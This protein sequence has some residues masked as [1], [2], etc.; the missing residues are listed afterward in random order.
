MKFFLVLGK[1]KELSLAEA[2]VL[3]QKRLNTTSFVLCGEVL[4]FEAEKPIDFWKELG[5]SI[6]FGE[7]VEDI[8]DTKAIRTDNFFPFLDKEK[9]NFFGVSFYGEKNL[10]ALRFKIGMELKRELENSGYKIRLV[11]SKEETLSS[12]VVKTNKLLTRGMEAVIINCRDAKF[13]VSTDKQGITYNPILIGR[14]LAVQEFGDYEF[15]DYGRPKRDTLSGM[16]PPKLA[17]MMINLSGVEK[18]SI[19]LDPFCGSGTILT[20]AATMGY[21]N[22][23]GAD[24]SERAVEDSKKNFEWTS[25]SYKLSAISYNFFQSDVRGLSKKIGE[26]KVNAIITEPYLGPPLKGNESEE[27][28][29]KILSELSSLYKDTFESLY[30]ITKAGAMM[31]IVVPI[32]RINN[33]EYKINLEVGMWK[34]EQ[35]LFSDKTLKLIW[36]RPDQKVIREIKIYKKEA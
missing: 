4:M 2:V 16:I 11:T 21:K 30:K 31:V 33:I 32:I 36:S 24:L 7:I 19:I 35:I 14:T 10:P 28:I 6:K 1:N 8:K 13:C 3:L 12:V 27:R 15:R 17:K 22:L 34:E 5:G 23:I 26:D 18:D 20:E 9:K 25:K 29:K